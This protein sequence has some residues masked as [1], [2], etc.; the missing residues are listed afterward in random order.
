MQGRQ[1][2]HQLIAH[3]DSKCMLLSAT[4][5]NKTYLDLSSQLRLFIEDEDR[6]PIRP[7]RLIREMGEIEFQ[8][9][10]QAT[11][12]S[13]AAFEK[14]EYPD[15]WRDLM[16]L[17]MVRR[18]R[19]FIQANYA[20]TDP[21]THRRYLLLE[22]GTPNYFPSRVPRTLKFKLRD[23]D[24][25]DQYAR[26]Y[27][28]EV[29]DSIGS[30]R[31]PRYGLGNYTIRAAEAK[32]TRDEAA[33]LRNLARAGRR[34]M[35]FCRTNLFKRLESSG[36]AFIQSLE[37]HIL[38]N[39][40][41]VHAIEQGLPIPIG[42]QDAGLLDTRVSDE[43]PDS[44]DALA[45]VSDDAEADVADADAAAG[46]EAAAGLANGAG[47]R[48]TEAEFRQRAADAY[49][50]YAS[51]YDRRFKWVRPALFQPSLAQD[52]LVDARALLQVLQGSG[53]WDPAQDAKLAELTKL[54]TRKHRGDKVLV[55]SQ[56]ADT[57][58]YLAKQ[59]EQRGVAAAAGATGDSADPT[60]YAWRFSPRSNGKGVP[61]HQQLRVLVA[62]DVLSEGQNLQDAFVVVNYDLPWAIIRLI[63]RAG[64]GCASGDA[65]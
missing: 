49:Q 56:F 30:L 43:D 20:L 63:Q 11:P 27:T 59:L 10:H 61:D 65:H 51:R 57:V 6:L 12:Y 46:E 19:S 4:P 35:G 48:Y 3:N 47:P 21:V 53:A 60:G 16:R 15:D 54:L 23:G 52:L 37:R 33:V 9:Q 25:A 7:E 41:V 28:P 45:F 50:M 8:A 31:L 42:T 40:I 62:T 17:Y 29:V 34:L 24:P 44:L 38:R 36:Q 32:A 1:N 64:R 26:L 14:S 13:I 5:Y 55:F 18:T 22:D 58:D 39:F 2:G